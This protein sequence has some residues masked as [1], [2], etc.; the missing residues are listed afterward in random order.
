MNQMVSDLARAGLTGDCKSRRRDRRSIAD[1]S[2]RLPPT[3]KP[4]ANSQQRFLLGPDDRE[5]PALVD[6]LPLGIGQRCFAGL[7]LDQVE[8]ARPAGEQVDRAID[9][10]DA[11]TCALKRADNPR[12]RATDLA[13]SQATG[14][15]QA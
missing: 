8:L 12:L 5:R 13:R 1:Q 11:T 2:Q 7:A 15:I 6:E 9:L 10:P 4:Q 3:S 14:T